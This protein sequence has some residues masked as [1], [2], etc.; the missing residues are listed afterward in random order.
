MSID[1]A[2]LALMVRFLRHMDE[3]LPDECKECEGFVKSIEAQIRIE[4]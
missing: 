3:H 4:R 1:R 2:V